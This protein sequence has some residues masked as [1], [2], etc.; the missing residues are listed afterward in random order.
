MATLVATRHGQT[1][2]NRERR[3]QG[4]APVG[5]NET[6]REQVADLAQRLRGTY[7]VDRIVSSDLQRT[8]ETA[9]ILADVLD[10]GEVEQDRAFRERDL[11]VL[12]GLLYDEAL[13]YHGE[14]SATSLTSLAGR[15]EG[16]ESLGDLAERVREGI[17]RLGSAVGPEETVVLVTHGGPLRVLLSD[18][19]SWDLEAAVD[20]HA[21][22]NADHYPLVLRKDGLALPDD[23]G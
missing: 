15:P 7:A 2:W 9:E 16:G 4:W 8:F 14:E 12:Q 5:L 6:G 11:G 13:A 22:S 23:E 21:P 10:V 3:I 19:N 18:A 17:D 1:D 20:R